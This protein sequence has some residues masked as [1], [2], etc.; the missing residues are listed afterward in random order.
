MCYTIDEIKEKT[1]PIAITYGIQ[2]FDSK[3]NLTETMAYYSLYWFKEK[4][5]LKVIEL[6]KKFSRSY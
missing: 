1:I 4:V 3:M 2:E 5:I 6:N